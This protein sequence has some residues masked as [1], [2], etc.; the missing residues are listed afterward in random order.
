MKRADKAAPFGGGHRHATRALV[1]RTATHVSLIPP[2]ESFSA[3]ASNSNQRPARAANFLAGLWLALELKSAGFKRC[4]WLITHDRKHYLLAS[5]EEIAGKDTGV[6]QAVPP[7]PSLG[8][9]LELLPFPWA[10]AKNC[11]GICPPCEEAERPSLPLCLAKT[12]WTQ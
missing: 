12:F 6:G 7:P 11:R 8:K 4:V 9:L 5:A 3:A 10:R 1:I 2:V